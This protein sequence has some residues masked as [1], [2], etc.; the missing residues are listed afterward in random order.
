MKD[1]RQW[2]GPDKEKH[3]Q[4]PNSYQHQQEVVVRGGAV[5]KDPWS[6]CLQ[7]GRSCRK[8]TMRS[9][10]GGEE[11]RKPS[12]MRQFVA[13]CNVIVASVILMLLLGTHR[14]VD[15]DGDGFMTMM[16][17]EKQQE[18]QLAAVPLLRKGHDE[19]GKNIDATLIATTSIP[20]TS[21]EAFIRSE[22]ERLDSLIQG[23]VI[24]QEQQH[25]VDDDNFDNIDNN[26]NVLFAEASRVWCRRVGD[27]WVVIEVE[28]EHDV[29]KSMPILAHLAHAWNF[30][31]RVRSG[32]HHKAGFS[33]VEGGAVLS[34]VRINHI[35]VLKSSLSS[36][37]SSAVAILGPAVQ[38][39][40]FLTKVLAVHGFSG[41]IGFCN[42]VAEGGFVLG[43]GWGLQSR[44]HGL[45]ADNVHSLRVVLANGTLLPNVSAQTHSDLFWAL[46]GA[47][48]GNF[49]VVT[50]IKYQIHKSSDLVLRASLSLRPKDM[51]TFLYK[52]G[53]MEPLLPGNLQLDW[54]GTNVTD[55]YHEVKISWTGQYDQDIQQS[56]AFVR[57]LVGSLVSDVEPVAYESDII[58]WSDS[59]HRTEKVLAGYSQE[60]WGADCWTGFLLPE[61]NTDAIWNDIMESITQ[62]LVDSSPYLMPCVEL[63]GGAIHDTAWNETAFPYR[64]AIYNLGVLLW[65]PADEANAEEIFAEQKAAVNAWWPKVA[66]YLQ[67]SY[68]NYPMSSLVGTEEYP[69]VYWAD[70]LPRL[71]QVKQRYDPHG[72][73]TFPLAVP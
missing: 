34:L 48:G 24:F 58:S 68:V 31:F 59:A 12:I 27:P 67:G 6:S 72:V 14:G 64:S 70:N 38:V 18:Q 46:R 33:S 22:L 56:D 49:G 15:D 26:G 17:Q 16:M 10:H 3:Q 32:G 52:M 55:L 60:V 43:G 50:E 7:R 11:T 30:P 2:Q 4:L 73:F 53:E 57:S 35:H 47:G 44:L 69:N 28:N 63:W 36:S 25:A 61:N 9:S 37:S 13:I 8:P 5:E 1:H 23:S 21:R 19:I 20:R 51:G 29:E 45:G 40:D 39:A 66:R 65:I 71:V 41:V 62:G 54:D 42:N